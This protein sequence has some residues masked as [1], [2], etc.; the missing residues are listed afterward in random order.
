MD[1]DMDMDMDMNIRRPGVVLNYCKNVSVFTW[2]I[3]YDKGE[4]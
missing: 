3:V 4:S 2:D 1:M